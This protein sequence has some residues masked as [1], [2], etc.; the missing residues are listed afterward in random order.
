MGLGCHVVLRGPVDA[1]DQVLAFRGQPHGLSVEGVGQAV[2]RGHVQR[3]DSPVGPTLAGTRE[4]VRR[5]GHG[6]LTAGDDDGGVTAA[7]H[8]GGV[9][10]GCE[11]GKAHFVDSDRGD[12]PAD[13]GADGAL[14]RRV[15]ARSRL[16]HLAHDD[17]IHLLRGNAARGEGRLDGMR[18]ELHRRE[19]GQLSVEAALRRAG[20]S[21][22]DNI[23][24]V[25]GVAHGYLFR[26]V[27][28]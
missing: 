13:A 26:S 2:M 18:P 27:T 15:L 3:L 22:D 9:D 14:P 1:Q 25:W 21:E 28:M 6:F 7:D 24:V 4:D 16:Q 11:A 17:R 10:H 19:A 20:R 8:A 5:P 23:V 12:V